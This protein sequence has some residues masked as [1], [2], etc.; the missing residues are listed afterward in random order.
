MKDI[1]HVLAFAVLAAVA[2]IIAMWAT[3]KV[4]EATKETGN[5]QLTLAK[6]EMTY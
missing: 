2:N 3:A 6:T 5:I 4:Q 1:K